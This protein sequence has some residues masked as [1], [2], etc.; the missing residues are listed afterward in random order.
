MKRI[1][2]FLMA[3][4]LMVTATA[5]VTEMSTVEA[6]KAGIRLSAKKKTLKKGQNFV[7]KCKGTKKKVK[8]AVS[9]KKVLKVRKKTKRA[10]Y[11]KAYRTGKSVVTAKVGKKKI[12]C[13]V[14]VK[15]KKTTPTTT[16]KRTEQPI[17]VTTEKRTEQLTTTTTEQPT[18][19]S[20]T[21][22]TEVTTEQLTTE[23]PTT[24]Q[25]TTITIEKQTTE[26]STTITTEQL[27]EIPT[28]TVT[29]EQVTEISTTEMTEATTEK[30]TTEQLTTEM[31]EATTEQL[32]T[33]E[34]SEATTELEVHAVLYTG[35][36]ERTAA[37][38]AHRD[39]EAQVE[40]E[41]SFDFPTYTG[42][43]TFY[44]GGYTGGC[45]NLDDITNGYY[46]CAM[47]KPQY[48]IAQLAG[49]YIEITGPT[50]TIKALVADELPEGKYGDVDMNTELFPMVAHVEDGRVPI[51]WKIIP[52]PTD[53]PIKYWIKADSTQYWMQIQIRNHRYPIAKFE[54]QKE[55]GTFVEVPKR[56]YNFFELGASTIGEPGP[57]PYTFRVTDI[58]GQVLVDTIPFMPGYIIDGKTNFDY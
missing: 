9:N 25:L 50:G 48:N 4:T 38:Y 43:G 58:N 13:V 53:E 7:I 29:T 11:L 17:V 54:I 26:Q 2:S 27:T 49:T 10:I 39:N 42:D 34:L 8:W 40:I 57:G 12:K 18:E 45:C 16:Q 52:F 36:T 41:S 3:A 31:T 56:N 22:T 30:P 19:I 35:A 55:D 6:A 33:E 51:S 21:E 32:T 37:D 44:G 47:N 28:T 24:E 1:V 15:K 14:N 23:E 20:T 5:P 46:V